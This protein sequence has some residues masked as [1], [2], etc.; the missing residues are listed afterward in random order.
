[1]R[2]LNGKK[3]A[4]AELEL[5]LNP[6]EQ[7]T[8]SRVLAKKASIET[9]E[10]NLWLNAMSLNRTEILGFIGTLIDRKRSLDFTEALNLR[11][12]TRNL[13]I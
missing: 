11:K 2:H 10:V 6:N 3:E 8:L 1:M 9:Q 13:I 4:E 7:K 5:H 12:E